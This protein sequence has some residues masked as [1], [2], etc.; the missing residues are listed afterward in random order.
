MKLMITFHAIGFEKLKDDLQ[1]FFLFF[2]ITFLKG[3]TRVYNA[4]LSDYLISITLWMR[5]R[6]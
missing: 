4:T 6:V 1:E 2:F 5:F 3:F